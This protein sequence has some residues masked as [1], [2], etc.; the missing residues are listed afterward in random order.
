MLSLHLRTAS[1]I[2][3]QRGISLPPCFNLDNSQ[4]MDIIEKAD[5]GLAFKF[6]LGLSSEHRA[7]IY[8]LYYQDFPA[9]DQLAHPPLAQVSKL[10]RQEALPVLYT[11]CT[12]ILNTEKGHAD[13]ESYKD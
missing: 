2:C 9:L 7:R 11:A 10:L 1:E 12:F 13:E 6:F 5:D 4:L 3:N 8:T